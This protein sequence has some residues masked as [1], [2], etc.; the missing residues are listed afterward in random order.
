MWLNW[1]DSPVVFIAFVWLFTPKKKDFFC[2]C[3]GIYSSF[4]V[5]CGPT[6][7]TSTIWQIFNFVKSVDDIT[8]TD[9]SFFVN[10]FY[11]IY[12]LILSCTNGIVVV[13]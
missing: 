13:S 10:C 12:T 3:N 9:T 5:Q 6:Y 1:K 7:L 4:V 2:S 11:H 8:L